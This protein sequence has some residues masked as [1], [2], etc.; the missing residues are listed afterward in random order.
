MMTNPRYSYLSSSVVK[1]IAHFG[2]NV[3]DFVT[4]EVEQAMKLK[5]KRMDGGAK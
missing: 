4:P 5:F 3:S 1:E 2:G